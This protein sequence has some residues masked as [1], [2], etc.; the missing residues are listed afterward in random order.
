MHRARVRPWGHPQ[1]CTGVSGLNRDEWCR[2]FAHAIRSV[3]LTHSWPEQQSLQIQRPSARA[4]MRGGGCSISWGAERRQRN[5]GWGGGRG[6]RLGGSS[7]S[8][9]LAQR[10]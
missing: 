10:K 4:S 1:G 2:P 3:S 5:D 8:G 9:L 7:A 6:G